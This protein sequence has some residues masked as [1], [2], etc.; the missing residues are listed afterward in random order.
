MKLRIGMVG[1]GGIA[2]VHINNLRDHELASITAVCD[3]V[4]GTALERAA[5][6]G[7]RPYTDAERMLEEEPL[8]ALFVC[9][10]P[11]AHGEI[12]EKAAARGIHLLVE[13]PQGLDMA[14]VRR[15]AAAI[16]EAGV[17]GTVGYC[18]RYLEAADCV[19]HYLRNRDIAMIR[20]E[21]FGRLP[22]GTP[23]Y[24]TMAKSGGQL[25]EQTTHSVDLM[26]YLAASDAVKVYADMALRVMKH[27]PEMDIPEVSSVSMVFQSGVLGH[28][29]TG[30]VMPGGNAIEIVGLDFRVRMSG[31]QSV[32]I[33]ERNPDTN[34]ISSRTETFATNFS[35]RQD[36]AFLQ[37]V[38]TGDRS[39]LRTDYE[40]AMRTLE[41][42]LAANRSAQSG[43]PVYLERSL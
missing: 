35:R 40:D 31:F 16:R 32:T 4:E 27:V 17:I 22:A 1:L 37:A 29:D 3:V 18:L 20:A 23:W 43:L 30:V 12:E 19:K 24:K 26:R 36:D 33:E 28:V 6:L 39:L 2:A 14:Q 34:E 9:V 10:P 11:F 25:V 38:A 15:K 5:E 42:T 13:K 41:I 21:R 8:D 7:A